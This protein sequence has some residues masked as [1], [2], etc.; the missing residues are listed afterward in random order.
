MGFK[1]LIKAPEST[2]FI[3]RVQIKQK[4][5]PSLENKLL[6]NLNPQILSNQKNMIENYFIYQPTIQT[7]FKKFLLLFKKM[8]KKRR[9]LLNVEK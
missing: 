6:R 1:L 4:K 7:P 9:N 3:K 8:K 2:Y 5:D